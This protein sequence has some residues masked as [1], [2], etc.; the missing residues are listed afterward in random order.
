MAL[1]PTLAATLANATLQALRIAARIRGT[2]TYTWHDTS[3]TEA[4]TERDKTWIDKMETLNHYKGLWF[5][6]DFL[7]RGDLVG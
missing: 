1:E 6:A 7:R 2:E 3:S 4:A 5:G